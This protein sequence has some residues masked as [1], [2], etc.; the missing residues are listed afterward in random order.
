MLT[1]ELMGG[2]GNQLFQIFALLNCAFDSK[3]KFVFEKGL[4]M[5]GSRQVTYWDNLFK[6]IS[7]NTIAK[8]IN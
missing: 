2:L 6:N 7:K 8:K 5:P 3:K 1:V 4:K